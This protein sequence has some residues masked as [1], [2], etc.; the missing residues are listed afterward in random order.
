[1][2]VNPGRESGQVTDRGGGQEGNPGRGPD[3]T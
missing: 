2:G 3:M 1:M